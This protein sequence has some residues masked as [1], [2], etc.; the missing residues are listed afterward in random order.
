[1]RA[2]VGA[3]LIQ[4]VGEPERG[5][6]SSLWRV[7]QKG[8]SYARWEAGRAAKSYQEDSEDSADELVCEEKLALASSSLFPV[9][10]Y[11]RAQQLLDRADHGSLAKNPS[12]E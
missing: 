3:V 11:E 2:T 5:D 7:K 10:T 4:E 8:I 9:S 12:R 1:V 6:N